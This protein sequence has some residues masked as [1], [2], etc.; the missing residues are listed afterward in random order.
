MSELNTQLVLISGYSASGK[1]ASLRNLR[2]QEKWFYCGCEAGKSLPCKNSFRDLRIEDPYQVYEAFDYGTEHPEECE[3]IIIDSLTFLMDMYESRYVLTASDTR[4]AWS[5]YS[6]F[7]KNLMQDKILKFNKP[8]VILAHTQDYVDDKT[9]ELKTY[10]PIKGALKAQGVESFFT[11]VVSTKK[12]PLKDLEAYKNDMLHIT[13][14]E[15][16]LGFK[17]CFQTKL[18]KQTL[19]ERIR[20]PMG[21]FKREETFIDNDVQILL[22]HLKDYYSN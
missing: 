11:T 17:Y 20:S 13:E 8:T 9:L 12:M 7:F 18:S 21:M 2:N 16:L 15:E 10:V 3:G 14:D 19:G 4:A 22:D 6:Q 1:S 5:S